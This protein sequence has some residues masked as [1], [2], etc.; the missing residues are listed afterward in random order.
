MSLCGRR[1]RDSGGV[2]RCGATFRRARAGRENA[3]ELVER[4]LDVGLGETSLDGELQDPGEGSVV[5]GRRDQQLVRAGDRAGR[6]ASVP[7]DAALISRLA[8]LRRPQ[9][10]ADVRPAGTRLGARNGRAIIPGPMRLVATPRAPGC[11]SS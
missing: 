1:D 7:A 8:V 11:I 10:P 3:D 5:L 4:G 2:T 9:T 6:V